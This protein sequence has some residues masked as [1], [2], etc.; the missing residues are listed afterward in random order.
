MGREESK[1]VSS[2]CSRGGKRPIKMGKAWRGIGRTSQK[3]VKVQSIRLG[4]GGEEERP[5]C[6]RRLGKPKN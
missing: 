5:G 6:Q 1:K 2:F 4:N 3:N